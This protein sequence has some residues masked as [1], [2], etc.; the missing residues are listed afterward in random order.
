MK[1]TNGKLIS[2]G[3]KVK[4]VQRIDGRFIG[5]SKFSESIIKE[6]I[7]KK[8]IHK[9]LKKNKKLDF[10]NFLMRLIKNKFNVHVIKKRLIGLNL[11]NKTILKLMPK[12]IKNDLF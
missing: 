12:I 1:I 11:T 6:L 10:T 5:I 3:K 8:I 9:N 2:L 4:N 7:D